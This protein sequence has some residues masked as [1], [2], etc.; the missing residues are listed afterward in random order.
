MKNHIAPILALV[1]LAVLP[2]S[3]CG[4]P[5]P[6]PVPTVVDAGPGPVVSD[7]SGY[8]DHLKSLPCS[9][10]TNPKCQATC[11]KVLQANLIKLPVECVMAATTVDAAIKCGAECK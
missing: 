11:E 8:C 6:A 1:S 2:A 7:C 9:E 5:G 10:G 4:N 3:H